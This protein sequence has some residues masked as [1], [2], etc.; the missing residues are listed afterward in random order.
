MPTV[1]RQEAIEAVGATLLYL[2]PYYTLPAA[3][4]HTEYFGVLLNE[5]HKA[6]VVWSRK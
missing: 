1:L 2:L 3:L 5:L 6:H 4:L